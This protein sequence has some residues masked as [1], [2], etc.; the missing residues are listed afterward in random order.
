MH[1]IINKKIIAVPVD[2]SRIFE[3]LHKIKHESFQARDS[4]RPYLF[5]LLGR[6]IP[7]EVRE[8]AIDILKDTVDESVPLIEDIYPDMPD[9]PTLCSK[10]EVEEF[11]RLL[12]LTFSGFTFLLDSTKYQRICRFHICGIPFYVIRNTE[13]GFMLNEARP[14]K[15]YLELIYS[16]WYR[17]SPVPR[18]LG[19]AFDEDMT[20]LVRMES[21]YSRTK[22]IKYALEKYFPDI[23]KEGGADIGAGLSTVSFS[24]MEELGWAGFDIVEPS[25]AFQ[26]IQREWGKNR[27][28]NSL[29]E[30]IKSKRKF[31]L[32]TCLTVLEHVVDPEIFLMGLSEITQ[33]GAMLFLRIPETPDNGP[34]G[35]CMEHL[36]HFTKQTIKLF[37]EAAGFEF[38]EAIPSRSPRNKNSIVMCVIARKI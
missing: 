6:R 36:N 9:N 28:F 2:T 1:I 10:E 5:S 27:I 31:S 35:E 29:E 15:E 7:L 14:G 20:W 21:A 19:F 34:K 33:P 11:F 30:L 12:L 3:K 32:V 4:L 37:L 17:T 24:I 38:L 18:H 22:E 8:T 26:K 13:S 23:S 25:P 16:A